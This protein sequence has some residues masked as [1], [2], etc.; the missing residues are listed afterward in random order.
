MR[1]LLRSLGMAALLAGLAPAAL[2]QELEP[3]DFCSTASDPG[4][5]PLPGQI[6]GSL[7]P[8]GA[9]PPTDVDFFRFSAAP[10]QRL[11]ATLDRHLGAV[12]DSDCNPIARLPNFFIPQPVDFEV[13][14]SG[15][16]FI[17][18]ADVGDGAFSGNGS[19]SSLGAY[20][21][22]LAQSP[23]RIGSISGR[24]IDA[25]GDFPLPGGIHPNGFILLD[26]CTPDGCFPATNQRADASGRVRFVLDQ[27]NRPL[28]AG[29][30]VLTALADGYTPIRRT[31][32]VGEDEHVDV[33]DLPLDPQPVGV[34]DVRTCTELPIQGGV[35]EFSARIRN[36]SNAPLAVTAHS[37]VLDSRS[38]V[39]FEAS[40]SRSGAEARRARLR[41]PPSGSAPVAF[42]FDVPSFNGDS[43]ICVQ[44]FVGYEPAPFFNNARSIDLFCVVKGARGLNALDAQ[45]SRAVFEQMRNAA[46]H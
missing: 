14:A 20:A 30:Y 31:L 10:G 27:V 42:S 38:Q 2:A 40:T 32:R 28:L 41:I 17:G 24:M 1:C 34:S 7:D 22:E 25:A 4:A 21:I 23:A 19:G 9:A 6:V 29:D 46:Q 43:F 45:A 16:F 12:F 3:N 44:L 37:V 5:I 11:R 15:V 33:G 18:V 13:P 39:R 26:F 35:C 8:Q 36:N